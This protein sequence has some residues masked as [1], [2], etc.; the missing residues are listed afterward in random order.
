MDNGTQG[1][2]D[3]SQILENLNEEEYYVRLPVRIFLGCVM[4]IG[5]AG[6]SHVLYIYGRFFKISTYRNFVLSLSVIDMIGCCLSMPFEIVDESMPY[7]FSDVTSC[8]IFRYLNTCVGISCGLTLVLVAIERYRKICHPQGTQLSE[9]GSIYFIVGV[10]LASF[11]I[12]SPALYLYGLKT[13]TFE[14]YDVK[15]TECTW[16]DH[17]QGTSLGYAYFGTAV[18][19]I[20]GCMVTMSILYLL[21]GIKMRSHRKAMQE[22]LRKANKTQATNKRGKEENKLT[23]KRNMCRSFDN[24]NAIKNPGMTNRLSN[25]CEILC[26]NRQSSNQISVQKGSNQRVCEEND[27]QKHVHCSEESK[28]TLN[29][30]ADIQNGRNAQLKGRDATKIGNLTDT[31][32][33]QILH[34]SESVLAEKCQSNTPLLKEHVSR[35]PVTEGATCSR[36]IDECDIP[37]ISNQQRLGRNKFTRILKLIHENGDQSRRESKDSVAQKVIGK[38]INLFKVD[39]REK[40]VTKILFTVT[41]LFILSFLP[42]VVILIVYSFDPMYEERMTSSEQVVYLIALRL[43]NINSAA[44]SILYILFD[45]KFR[46]ELRQMYSNVISN[47]RKCQ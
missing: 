44:N 7:N 10:I 16:A 24:L 36:K 31:E 13:V 8:K 9:R 17:A 25:S 37:K 12:S 14:N 3:R 27:K 18:L 33:D 47:I 40:R 26:E 4:A 43:Y 19:V 21:V 15:G 38:M 45:R 34:H 2:I 1:N 6:N 22:N 46:K 39:D 41:L 28:H 32:Q 35:K 23:D 30:L 42:Y 11:I 20:F 29:D 5:I